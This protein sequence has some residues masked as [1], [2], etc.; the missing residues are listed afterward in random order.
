MSPFKKATVKGGSSKG[1]EPVI[2][3][4][5]YSPQSK[6]TRSSS[7]GFDPNKFRS[8][9]AF[10]SHENYFR[11]A[12]SLL[13]RPVDQSSLHDTDIPK[14]FAHKDWNYLLSDLDDTYENLVKE[15]YANAIVE[16]EELKCWVRK[17]SF[18]VSPAYLAE[19]LH[20]NR[21]LLRHSPVYDDLCPDEELLK[22][23]LGQDLEFSSKGNS[24]SVPLFLQN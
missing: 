22:E 6:G 21:P 19:I 2:D 5:D 15:F 18:S 13:E 7:K 17:K 12:T 14:W 20:I 1:K 11:N 8:Y 9:A 24:V 16:G 23:G 3:A 10:Q 4:D